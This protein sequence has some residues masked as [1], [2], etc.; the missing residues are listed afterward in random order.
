MFVRSAHLTSFMCLSSNLGI[1]E[2]EPSLSLLLMTV[3]CDLRLRPFI[4]T[5]TTSVTTVAPGP[6]ILLPSNPTIGPRNNRLN[7][8]VDAISTLPMPLIAAGAPFGNAMCLMR[9]H[10]VQ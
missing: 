6:I 4:I 5:A 2:V 9:C 10:N 7:E 8:P 3:W 1:V